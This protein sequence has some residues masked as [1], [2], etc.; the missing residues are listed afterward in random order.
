MNITDAIQ[1]HPKFESVKTESQQSALALAE[2]LTFSGNKL[3]TSNL[4]YTEQDIVRKALV[5]FFEVLTTDG[6]SFYLADNIEA[7]AK[8]VDVTHLVETPK[9]TKTPP[10][11]GVETREPRDQNEHTLCIV[12]SKQLQKNAMLVTLVANVEISLESFR[13]NK[14]FGHTKKELAADYVC[15]KTGLSRPTVISS[16]EEA[17]KL[18]FLERVDNG[19]G[20]RGGKN[21]ATYKATL[22]TYFS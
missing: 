4:S 14:P 8:P 15:G 21:R 19:K 3:R 2:K 1:N 11:T 7:N 17:V 12:N 9:D 20:G 22:P 16:M 13:V 10:K 6:R 5:D 18:G